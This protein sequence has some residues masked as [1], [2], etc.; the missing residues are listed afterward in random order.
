MAAQIATPRV[1]FKGNDV[2]PRGKK[3]IFVR[4]RF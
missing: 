3:L 1:A 4:N 2:L